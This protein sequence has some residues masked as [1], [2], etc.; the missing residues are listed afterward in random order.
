MHFYYSLASGSTGNC[1]L[2]CVDNTAILID[3]GLS[4]TKLCA[5]LRAIALPIDRIA[6]V[7][8]THTHSDHI[9][10]MAPLLRKTTL[11][12]YATAEAVDDWA[13]KLSDDVQEKLEQR[14]I[15][16]T[17]GESQRIGDITVRCFPT[18]HDS[19]GSVGYI[20]ESGQQQPYKFGFV[21]DL[22]TVSPT[23][24]QEMYGCQAAVIESNYD[25]F[26]L[27][28]GSYP[29]FLK[30]RIRSTTG[31]L[32]NKECAAFAADLVQHGATRLI[33]SHLSEKNNMPELAWQ[34]TWCALAGMPPCMVHIAPR[35]CMPAPIPLEGKQLGRSL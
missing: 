17:P 8:L 21:T 9:K 34:E 2:Y 13:P 30:D 32:S 20:F 16:W 33:L 3:A 24:A 29:A 28:V 15:R 26:L 11:P 35:D 4:F 27:Q 18:P 22:G 31:H 14:V 25:P 6:A 5:A 23:V 12:V 1:G 19:P 7:L 10:G